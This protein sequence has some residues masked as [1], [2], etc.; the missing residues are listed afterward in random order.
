M[1]AGPVGLGGNIMRLLFVLRS[2]SRSCA[3]RDGATHRMGT[4]TQHPSMREDALSAQVSGEGEDRE[5]DK[6]HG[7]DHDGTVLAAVG[8]LCHLAH[9]T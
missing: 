3:Q 9:L 7:Q 5:E 2:V 4:A 6:Q 8:T 1:R